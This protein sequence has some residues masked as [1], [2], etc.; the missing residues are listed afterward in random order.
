MILWR[1]AKTKF[2]RDLSGTG[3]KLVGG[4]WNSRGVPVLYAA[5]TQSLCALE[6]FVHLDPEDAPERLSAIALTIP[7]ALFAARTRWPQATLPR[8]WR[9]HPAPV[10]LQAMGDAW[11]KSGATL[12]LEVPSAVIPDEGN[13]ILNVMHPEMSQVSVGEPVAFTFDGRMW[14]RT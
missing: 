2:I 14:K 12:V 6:L 11:V 7:D 4:R 1:I 10:D 8:T 9:D 5:L 13:F 3:A